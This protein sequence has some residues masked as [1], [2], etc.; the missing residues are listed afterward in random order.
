MMKFVDAILPDSKKEF[1]SLVE[2]GKATVKALL[3]GALVASNTAACTMASAVATRRISWLEA[4]GLPQDVQQ[5]VQDLPLEGHSLFSIRLTQKTDPQVTGS[6]YIS[7][8]EE[9]F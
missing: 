5:S 8:P 2:E 6:T 9:V 3:Q 1:S 7:I 4:L